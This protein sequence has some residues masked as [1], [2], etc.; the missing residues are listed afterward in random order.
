M[1]QRKQKSFG[2]NTSSWRLGDAIFK[3]LGHKTCKWRN[4]N[5]VQHPTLYLPFIY[6]VAICFTDEPA[7]KGVP[8][9]R[10]ALWGWALSARSRSAT[11]SS[12]TGLWGMDEHSTY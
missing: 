9:V 2:Q 11:L 12:W 1:R 5:F 6:S 3:L 8:G 4:S 10:C 7:A